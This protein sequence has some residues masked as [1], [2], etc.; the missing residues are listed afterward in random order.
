M[1][2]EAEVSR[3]ILTALQN[4]NI[5]FPDLADGTTRDATATRKRVGTLGA[6]F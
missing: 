1:G 4:A 3:I 2:D 5:N 6:P